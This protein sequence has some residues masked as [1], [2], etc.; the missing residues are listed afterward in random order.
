M[1]AQIFSSCNVDERY[2]YLLYEL[3]YIKNLYL[4]FII[5]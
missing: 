1:R 5:C 4:S 3:Y 2:S